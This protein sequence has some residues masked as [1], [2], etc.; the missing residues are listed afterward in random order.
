MYVVYY[1]THFEITANLIQ[2]IVIEIYILDD[3]LILEK[4][5]DTEGILLEVQVFKSVTQQT[6]IETKWKNL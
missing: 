1:I 2:K 4:S 5:G 6:T 3:N